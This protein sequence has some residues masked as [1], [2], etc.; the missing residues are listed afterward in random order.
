MESIRVLQDT[1]EQLYALSFPM[2]QYLDSHLPKLE[3]DWFNK[4]FLDEESKAENYRSKNCASD[5]DIYYQA[6]LLNKFWYKLKKLFP[7]E[8]H[9]YEESNKQLVNDIKDIRNKIMHVDH[10]DYSYTDFYNDRQTIKQVAILFGT[11]IEKLIRD[12]HESEKQKLLRIIHDEVIAPAIASTELDE[13]IKASVKNTAER[14]SK[15]TSAREIVDF[16]NDALLANK[17]KEIYQ[18]FHKIGLKGF[19]DI[20]YLIEE[21]YYS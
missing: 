16:F 6:K 4:L 12:L 18:A 8:S 21:A 1:F 5:L 9:F 13:K 11:P 10:A 3:K 15:K 14:L 7:D 2:G 19:E 20:G 17:G